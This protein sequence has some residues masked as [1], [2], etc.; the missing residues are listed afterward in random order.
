MRDSYTPD[1][2]DWRDWR[3][4]RRFDPAERY[5]EWFD[6]ITET[7]ARGVQVR[8]ARIVSE[9]VTDYIRFEYDVT[10][11]LNIA[12][13]EQ[14][15]WLPRRTAAD[16]LVPGS[17]FWI[18]DESVVVFNHFDGPGNWIGQDRRDD[19]ELAKRHAS[20]FEAIWTRAT[21]HESYRLA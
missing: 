5:R 18:F 21:P 19:E 11:G 20:A 2:P 6:L 16:L 15:R 7:I 1:D 13:G 10:A 4:G 3:E 17:D 8:R 14:V 9:P 12:A